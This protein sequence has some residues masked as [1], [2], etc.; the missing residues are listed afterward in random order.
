MLWSLMTRTFLWSR[1]LIKS[2][3]GSVSKTSSLH[4]VNG[5]NFFHLDLFFPLRKFTSL[6]FSSSVLDPIAISISSREWKWWKRLSFSRFVLLNSS[7]LFSR[8]TCSFLFPSCCSSRFILRRHA[9]ILLFALAVVTYSS[10]PC[11]TCCVLEVI[12][13]TWSPPSSLYIKGFSTWLTLAPMQCVP[14]MVC[15]LKAKSNAVAPAGRDLMSPFGVN[16]IIS[17]AKRL[18]FIVSRRSSVSGCGSSRIS[19]IVCNHPSI[20]SSF[21]SY[22]WFWFLYFQCAA[23]PFSSISSIRCERICTSTHT[24]WLLIKVTCNPW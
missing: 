22:T 1:L 15:M 19:L 7:S 6:L 3:L 16:T 23:T 18:S 17:L 24:P 8:N 11:F 4:D 21:S 20:L 10:H 5:R 9:W 12:I 13:S 14:S 2:M